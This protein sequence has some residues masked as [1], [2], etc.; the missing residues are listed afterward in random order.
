MLGY[1][2]ILRS[3]IE[4]ILSNFINMKFEFDAQ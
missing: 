2:N 4:G 1:I 3:N